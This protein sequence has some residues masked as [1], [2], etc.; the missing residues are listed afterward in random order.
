MIGGQVN[1]ET[2]SKKL[3]YGKQKE[4]EYAHPLDFPNK[5]ILVKASRPKQRGI[6]LNL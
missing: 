5:L 2:L 3:T 1:A 6:L 4:W